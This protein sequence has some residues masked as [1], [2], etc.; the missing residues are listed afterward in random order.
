MAQAEYLPVLGVLRGT[1]GIAFI[2]GICYLLSENRKAISWRV[3]FTGLA[4]QLMLGLGVIYVPAFYKLF[5]FIGRLFISVINFSKEGS[6]FLFGELVNSDK[7]GIIFA[8]QILPAIIF[9]GALTGALYYYGIIQ[10]VV[11]LL[12]RLLQRLMS[13][14]GPESL[15]TSANIFLGQ[16]ESPL[17]IKSYLE[18]M[19]RPEI[20][21]VMVAGMSML[22]GTVLAAYI[23]FLGGNDP[24]QQLI[25]AKHLIAASVMAAP[26]AIVIAKIL[27]PHTGEFDRELYLEKSRSETNVLGAIFN[28]TGDGLKLTINVG[29][30]LIV[31]VAFVAMF[32]FI[33]LKIGYW[34]HLNSYIASITGGRYQEL[35]LQFILGYC[36]APV[37]WVIGICPADMVTTG[38]LLGEKVMLTEFIGYINLSSLKAAGAFTQQKSVIMATYFL[39]GF[40]NFAS[41]GIQIGCIGSLAPGKRNMVSELG[42]K[43]LIAG[44]LVSLLSACLMGMIIG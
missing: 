30:M 21:Q 34:T 40:A 22:A 43:A 41:I 10:W 1:V 14:S 13:I 25:F 39:S 26:G 31:F 3:V 8:F 28:G 23:G 12:A 11:K 4:A 35:S 2:I 19:S 37:M 9:I 16:S 7:V 27:I 5:E 29:A 17:L 18:K 33:A 32:N 38:R 24:V 42:F 44:T 20:F 15:A 6:R 36:F